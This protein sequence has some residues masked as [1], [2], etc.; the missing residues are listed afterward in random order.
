MKKMLTVIL[1]AAL[2]FMMS[3]CGSQKETTVVKYDKQK[4]KQGVFESMETTDID[5]NV[6]NSSVFADYDLTLVN[7]WNTGCPPCINE[8]PELNQLNENMK[9]KNVSVK[10]LVYELKPGLSDRDLEA[11]REILESAGSSYQHLTVSE[12]MI[13]SEEIQNITAFP[14]T[15]FVNR[16]G[17]VVGSVRGA[18]D[19]TG[20]TELVEEI[21]SE[22]K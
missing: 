16:E 18:R 12:E 21:L 22:M 11:V 10:G 1:M 14:T 15:F 3:G 9:D 6:V 4:E 19:L 5:G 13:D 2:V 7:V 20:W 8:I 17:K